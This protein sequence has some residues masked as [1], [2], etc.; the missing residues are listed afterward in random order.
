[1]IQVKR[2][3]MCKKILSMPACA[4]LMMIILIGSA[5]VL[6]VPADENETISCGMI[7]PLSGSLNLQGTELKQGIELAVREINQQGGISGKNL[8]LITADDQGNP[9]NALYLFR[10]MT[11]KGIPVVIGSYS[12][13]LTLPLAEIISDDPST[14]LI[15]PRANG[16]VLYGISPA[17][18]QMNAPV[19]YMGKFIADWAIYTAERVAILY[20]DTEYGESFRDSVSSGLAGSSVKI[21]SSEPASEET[22]FQALSKNVLNGAPDII[23]VGIYGPMQTRLLEN[24]TQAGYR[25]QV[26]LTDTSLIPTLEHDYGDVLSKFSVCSISSTASTVPGN[27][28]E[29]FT[30][31]YEQIYGSDPRKGI[32]GYG[33]DSVYI[34]ADALRSQC[35]GNNIS[36]IDI[37]DGLKRTRYY[38]V[39]GPK[40]FDDSNVVHPALDRWVFRNGTFELM[41]TSYY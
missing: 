2:Q 3:P 1:M 37:L 30:Q 12:T 14:V 35:Y 26:V 27:H 22:D 23:I 25:G 4:H 20:I 15:S 19:H 5:L 10:E 33:Y 21:S 32:A 36:V 28:T 8:S 31:A 38:G 29:R 40:V 41:T 16:Q 39:T 34:I 9:E 18:F 13:D 24:L 17:F 7:L 6:P 11:Q